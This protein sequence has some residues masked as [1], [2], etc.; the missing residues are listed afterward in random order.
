M[1]TITLQKI[2]KK[3]NCYEIYLGNGFLFSF[4][5]ERAAKK[6]LADTSR[7]LTQHLHNLNNLYTEIYSQYRNAWGYFNHN[8][9]T[10][11]A[12]LLQ[13]ERDLKENIRS[14]EE[15]LDYT[16]TWIQKG[17]NAN[18]LI[19]SNFNKITDYCRATVFTLKDLAQSRSDTSTVYRCNDLIQRI[20]YLQ[21]SLKT[22]GQLEAT[23][24]IPLYSEEQLRLLENH[25]KLPKSKLA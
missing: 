24:T 2:N 14:A 10:K 25:S 23:G 20:S 12:A 1:K 8:K 21:H 4:K 19:F 15:L 5:S 11:K 16:V 3:G 13:S 22:Y 9:G 6:F 17:P 18:Y 7:F